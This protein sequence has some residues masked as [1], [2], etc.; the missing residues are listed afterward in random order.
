MTKLVPDGI[1]FGSQK[2]LNGGNVVDEPVPSLVVI[3]VPP[4]PN[5]SISFLTFDQM[6]ILVTM[7]VKFTVKRS[8]VLILVAI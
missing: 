1:G 8:P 7:T 2:G 5:D 3:P 4:V 6:M